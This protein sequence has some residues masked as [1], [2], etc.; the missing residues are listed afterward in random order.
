MGD[1]K[2][3]LG[4]YETVDPKDIEVQRTW[5]EAYLPY[6][7]NPSKLEFDALKF[8]ERVQR[9]NA[10]AHENGRVKEERLRR[11]A[12]GDGLVDVGLREDFE[13]GHAVDR[14]DGLAHDSK[15][16]TEVGANPDNHPLRDASQGVL[17]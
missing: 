2:A 8:V 3:R 5:A 13:A 6:P 1:H 7:A 10:S 12:E 16:V 15:S 9:R 17:P 11:S 4:K 14:G